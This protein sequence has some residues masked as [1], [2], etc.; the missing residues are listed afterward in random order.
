MWCV[1]THEGREMVAEYVSCV[2]FWGRGSVTLSLCYVRAGRR[3]SPRPRRG[4]EMFFL[5]DVCEERVWVRGAVAA[6]DSR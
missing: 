1:W 3:V 5:M 6:D 2:I 4:E